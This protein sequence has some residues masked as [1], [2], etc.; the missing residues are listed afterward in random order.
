MSSG[1]NS[2]ESTVAMSTETEK[3]FICYQCNETIAISISISSAAAAAD[4]VCHVCNGGF[5]EEYNA[6]AQ[7]PNQNPNLIFRFTDPVSSRLSFT[8]VMDFTNLSFLSQ[9]SMEEDEDEEEDDDSQS[10]NTHQHHRR[11]AFDPFRFLHN[12]QQLQSNGVNV[13]LLSDSD[14]LANHGGGDYFFGR[15]LE[16]DDD[17][18]NRYGT[19]PASK[20]AIDAL[21]NVK[22]DK[23]ILESEMNQCAVCIDEFEYGVFAKEMPCKHVYHRDCLLPWL[24]LHSSCPVCR[25]EL[26]TGDVDY[27]N[28]AAR[29]GHTRGGDDDDDAQGS[30]TTPFQLTRRRRRDT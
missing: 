16:E 4:P 18:P 20:S 5:L 22:V 25:H 28:R 30:I 29:G 9:Q 2:I 26:P 13:Q 27:E 10:N 24:K 8:P 11:E 17:D 23:E 14:S 7:E 6:A 12:I 21:P 15:G 19:P 1:E 3:M